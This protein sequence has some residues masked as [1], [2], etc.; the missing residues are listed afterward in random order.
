MMLQFLKNLFRI[1]SEQERMYDYLSQAQDLVHLEFLQKEYDKNRSRS[2]WSDHGNLYNWRMGI[3][4]P[5]K[6]KLERGLISPL[7]YV[8]VDWNLKGLSWELS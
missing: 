4:V 7:F 3:R 8:I 6:I 1:K 2:V 5:E